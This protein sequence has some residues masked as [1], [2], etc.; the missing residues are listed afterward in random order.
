VSGNADLGASLDSR[1]RPD[2]DS[3]VGL[4]RLEILR[5]RR[6]GL[7]RLPVALVA[8]LAASSLRV[9]DVARNA[10]A[11]VPERGSAPAADAAPLRQL[12][13]ADNRLANL[14]AMAAA[15][16]WVRGGGAKLAERRSAAAGVDVAGNLQ[17]HN[18]SA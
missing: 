12:D 16:S 5:A 10:I 17:L 1:R 18:G 4:D 13:L 11:A 9:V 6:V 15:Y 7:R 14:S 8:R 3:L 2:C